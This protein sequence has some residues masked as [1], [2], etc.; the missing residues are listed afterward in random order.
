MAGVASPSRC[1]NQL[2]RSMP[3]CFKLVMERS[4][5]LELRRGAAPQ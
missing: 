2:S 3:R 4:S 1:S 5:A